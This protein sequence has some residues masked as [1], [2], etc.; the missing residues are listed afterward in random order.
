MSRTAAL[1]DVRFVVPSTIECVLD[2]PYLCETQA[3]KEAK[4]QAVNDFMQNLNFE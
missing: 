2:L 1:G 3:E 4:E